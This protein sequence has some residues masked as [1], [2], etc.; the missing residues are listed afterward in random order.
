[1]KKYTYK[2][3]VDGSKGG[4]IKELELGLPKAVFYFVNTLGLS[5]DEITDRIN[6]MSILEQLSF[7]MKFRNKHPKVYE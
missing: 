1:M 6:G 2:D 5:Q 4:V 7:Y 3:M